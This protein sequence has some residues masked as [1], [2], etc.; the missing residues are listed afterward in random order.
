MASASA[1]AR[2]QGMVGHEGRPEADGWACRWV[3]LL[4]QPQQRTFLPRPWLAREARMGRQITEVIQFP[5]GHGDMKTKA[6]RYRDGEDIKEQLKQGRDYF[7]DD[8]SCYNKGGGECYTDRTPASAN[9]EA[10]DGLKELQSLFAAKGIKLRKSVSTNK[11]AQKSD[12]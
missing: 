12:D 3:R 5:F 9:R 10:E 8:G 4:P 2:H 11:A 6:E 7:F 1:S